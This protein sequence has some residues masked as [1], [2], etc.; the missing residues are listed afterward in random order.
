MSKLLKYSLSQVFQ[1]SSTRIMVLVF[2]L[3]SGLSLTMVIFSYQAHVDAAIDTEFATLRATT[4]S[5]S[6]NIDAELHLDLSKRYTEIDQIIS[7][8]DDDGYGE[9]ARILKGTHDV[10]GMQSDVYTLI[11][12]PR[13][14]EFQFMVT[15]AD[16][17]YFRHKWT[18]PHDEHISLYRSGA[19][20]GPYEDENGVWLSSFSPIKLRGRTVGI[21][22]ADKLFSEF[23]QEARFEFKETLLIFGLIFL[24][25]TIILHRIINRILTQDEARQKKLLDQANL[26]EIKNKDILSS[27]RVAKRLQEACLPN[28]STIRKDI[29][30][31]SVMYQPKDI[32]SGDFFWHE[33]VG[34]KVY[35]AAGDCT[36]HGIPGAFM[37]MMALTSLYHVLNKCTDSVGSLLTEL[38]I[39]IRDHIR[40]S[41]ES[42]EGMDIAVCS[43]D[44]E[45]CELRYAGAL[46]P[47]IVIREGELIKIKGDRTGIGGD[48]EGFEFKEH[49]VDVIPGDVIYMFSDGFSDQFGG[50]N[51]RKYM[52]KRFSEFLISIQEHTLE[53]QKYLIQYEF[54]LW[55]EDEEQVDDVLVMGFRIPDNSSQFRLSA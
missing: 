53:E 18:H 14:R 42:A 19:C 25:T 54:H 30:E 46:R 31:F 51:G 15:S 44:I 8:E 23:I 28:L 47:L 34:S 22:Q 45:T 52:S 35:L 40:S 39:T 11:M 36:G 16:E 20:I 17:P 5:L 32:V 4:Q 3:I 26:I 41:S 27:I 10:M 6:L 12:E 37:S 7:L 21:V 43:F 33:K 49:L 38:D 13:T 24:L 1:N 29:P 50:E 48:A 9:I 2:V 55:K